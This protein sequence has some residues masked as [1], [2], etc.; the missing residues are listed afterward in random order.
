MDMENL[1]LQMD[2]I[3]LENLNMINFMEKEDLYYIIL[4]KVWD[5]K[6]KIYDGE[7][8]CGKKNGFGTLEYIGKY[9][10]KGTYK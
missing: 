6:N 2:H 3:I 1:N 7:W 5:N 10:Y 8:E 9:I 4:F